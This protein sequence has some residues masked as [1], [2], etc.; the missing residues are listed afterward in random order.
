[1][2]GKDEIQTLKATGVAR[3][4][5][6]GA[7]APPHDVEKRFPL[8]KGWSARLARPAEEVDL[9]LGLD[10]QR[11]MPRHVSSSIMKE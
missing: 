8:A 6:F 4:T 1:M 9:L 2:D 7:S 10:N 5:S 3:I 11:W